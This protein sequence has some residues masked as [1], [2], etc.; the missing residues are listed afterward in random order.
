MMWVE[1]PEAFD[2]VRLNR[3]LRDSH[4]QIAVGSLFSASGKYRNCLRLSFA[5]TPDD[6]V[7]Q[8]LA[9]VGQAVE[10]AIAACAGEHSPHSLQHDTLLAK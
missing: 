7:E 2:A 4:I 10:R 6:R 8:A 9:K 3:E 5:V 1:L